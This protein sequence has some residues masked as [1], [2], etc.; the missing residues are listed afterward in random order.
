MLRQRDKRERNVRAIQDTAAHPCREQ[1]HWTATAP[2]YAGPICAGTAAA[3][4]LTV[5]E[6]VK[7]PLADGEGCL[8]DISA[9]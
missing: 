3:G 4:A 8:L 9:Q 5:R 1:P 7:V 6:H 2:G